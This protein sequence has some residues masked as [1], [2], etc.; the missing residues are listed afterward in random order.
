MLRRTSKSE[1]A[2][3]SSVSGEEN[4]ATDLHC[5][6]CHEKL[7]VAILAPLDPTGPQAAMPRPLPARELIVGRGAGADVDIAQ[8]KGISRRHA[9]LV[10]DRNQF[11]LIDEG[12]SF[13]TFL[14]D[15]QLSA[16]DHLAVRD[17]DEL[18]FGE[19]RFRI[20]YLRSAGL[21]EPEATAYAELARQLTTLDPAQIVTRGL[22]LARLVSSAD[23]SYLVSAG[24]DPHL[25]ALLTPLS[26]PDLRVSRSAIADAFKTGRTVSHFLD[27][28]ATAFPRESMRELDLRRIWVTPI[29]G[30][31]GRRV[32]AL[33]LD[34]PSS[35]EPFSPDVEARLETVA[36]HIGMAVR[37]ASL[38]A[39]VVSLNQTL[40][41]RVEERTRQL[42][43]SQTQLISQDRLVTLGR[44]VAAIAHEL[45]NPVGAIASFAGTLR[46]L[47]TPIMALRQEVD[48]LFADEAD[49]QATRAMLDE[50]MAAARR[51]ATDSRRRRELE[52][53]IATKL[54][55]AEVPSAS[56]V[57]QRLARMGFDPD[58]VET[59]IAL[60][61]AN[62]DRLTALI[63]QLYTFGR[64]VETVGQCADN[65]ARIVDGLKTYAHLDRS[66]A[67]VADI[68]RSIEA[69]LSVLAPRIPKG[70]EVITQFGSIAPFAH[71]PGELTQVWTNLVDNALRAMG[72]T[73]TL[74]LETRDRGQSVQVIIT[75]T[76]G[77]IP[78]AL[79]DRIFELDVTSRGPG[80]GLGLGLPIC[81]TIVERKHG[82]RISFTSRPGETI[83]TA[84]L[85]KT[86]PTESGASS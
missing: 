85:S 36:R 9:R 15:K 66:E 63:E 82:G 8:P 59:A 81:R 26:Q 39:Q 75:D 86:P 19:T 79:R 78:E 73:G 50:A 22:E 30:L 6:S 14:N 41:Q 28:Q 27:A 3:Q 47:M 56:L 7:P 37:N 24:N 44:L 12:S 31:D 57:A 42:E 13:G 54:A 80:A 23:R 77:G 35:G 76:G 25:D 49:R 17:G 51:P 40:E 67:E 18:R 29:E 34:S 84:E 4:S 83:F 10:W 38:Y 43:H 55:A 71:R 11:E 62:G 1:P 33:Y 69:T 16:G 70:V 65:V 2:R 60:L 74:R 48:S 58:R 46:G 32:A 5:P 64:S 68:H 45:N 53:R 72:E 61:A 20:R 52:D 21:P